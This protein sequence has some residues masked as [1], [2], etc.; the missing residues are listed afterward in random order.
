MPSCY[1]NINDSYCQ[2]YILG[3]ATVLFVDTFYFNEQL[4]TEQR[5]LTSMK[6]DLSDTHTCQCEARRILTE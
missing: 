3:G 6:N 2:T 1:I 5:C 4:V